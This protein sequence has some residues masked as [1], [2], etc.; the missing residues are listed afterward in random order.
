[1][2]GRIDPDQNPVRETVPLR[3]MSAYGR[4]KAVAEGL[5]LERHRRGRADLVVV[6]PFNL[7]GP[8]LP[9]GLAPS[10]FLAEIRRVQRGEG[11]PV[12]RVGNLEPRRDFVDVRDAVR[13]YVGLAE[14]DDAYG[15]AF[16][17]GSGRPTRIRDLLERMIALSG[18]Q[19]RVEIDPSRVRSEDLPEIVADTRELRRMVGWY[20]VISLD[21]SLRAMIQES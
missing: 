14:S 12:I 18:V 6:R 21:D 3:P 2:Y 9:L 16:N 4:T 20:P 7:I 5:A 15:Q 10:D 1:V 17:V 8:G 13:A 19:V 11:E